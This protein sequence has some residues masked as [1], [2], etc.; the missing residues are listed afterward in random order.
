MSLANV[1]LHDLNLAANCSNLAL[2][3]N[4]WIKEF[5]DKPIPD[6]SDYESDPSYNG[7]RDDGPSSDDSGYSDYPNF[8]TNGTSPE[9]LDFWRFSLAS[10]LPGSYLNLSNQEITNWSN[11]T[12]TFYFFEQDDFQLV[13]EDGKFPRWLSTDLAYKGGCH[14]TYKPTSTDSIFSMAQ[15]C[16]TQ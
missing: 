6:L 15:L 1:S 12:E 11:T 13:T 2:G 16:I 4:I 14:P 7:T 9:W 3:V 5:V 8:W 10:V